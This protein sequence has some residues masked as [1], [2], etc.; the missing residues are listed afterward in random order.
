MREFDNAPT[1]AIGTGM[2]RSG[3]AMANAGQPSGWRK[4]TAGLALA[5][6]LAEAGEQSS[7]PKTQAFLAVKRVGAHIGLKASDLM[8]LD[9]LGA[10]TQP[11][12]WEE[13]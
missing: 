3:G 1:G 5:E 6:Q 4:A 9:T 11:Q 2:P 8:L 10:F 7:V 13:V 12:D